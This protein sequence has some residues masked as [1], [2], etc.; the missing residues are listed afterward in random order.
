LL[1]LLPRSIAAPAGAVFIGGSRPQFG[2]GKVRLV[3]ALVLGQATPSDS[4]FSGVHARFASVALCYVEDVAD[5][6]DEVDGTDVFSHVMIIAHGDADGYIGWRH[7]H[8][9]DSVS[10]LAHLISV[11]FR[12]IHV[13]ACDFGLALCMPTDFYQRLALAL[14]NAGGD[15]SGHTFISGYMHT[16]LE[17]SSYDAAGD[18]YVLQ[19]MR[20]AQCD[21]KG[22]V[23]VAEVWRDNVGDL[24][25]TSCILGGTVEVHY[26][27]S[28]EF[29]VEEI[30]GFRVFKAAGDVRLKIKWLGYN[31]PSYVP[32]TRDFL[33]DNG[34]LMEDFLDNLTLASYSDSMDDYNFMWD[35]RERLQ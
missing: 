11:G 16:V 29:V 2:A 1:V 26:P 27:P 18:V 15:S 17:T 30:I 19:G 8:S 21:H 3:E 6:I 23:H 25:A 31:R 34:N 13:H 5:A 28:G 7:G 35:Q 4:S 14:T 32:L 12:R 22:L 20:T 9:E 10:L 33:D 24:I